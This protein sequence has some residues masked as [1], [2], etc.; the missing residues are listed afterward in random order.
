MYSLVVESSP[1]SCWGMS[2]PDIPGAQ[3]DGCMPTP[4]VTREQNHEKAG[5]VCGFPVHSI[6]FLEV[7]IAPVWCLTVA[8]KAVNLRGPGSNPGIGAIGI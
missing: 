8:C 5:I 6:T 4:T 2:N 1:V 7:P 3:V